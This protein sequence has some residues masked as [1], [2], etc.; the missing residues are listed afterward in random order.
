MDF[1]INWHGGSLGPGYSNS[2]YAL[3]CPLR[4]PVQNGR[5]LSE[6]II[7]MSKIALFKFDMKPRQPK[8]IL[9]FMKLVTVVL[10]NKVFVFGRV[11]RTIFED[12]RS[13]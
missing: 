1:I 11:Q 3:K 7:K 5:I 8:S 6:F 9:K 2:Q 13:L 12:L 10:W 4:F